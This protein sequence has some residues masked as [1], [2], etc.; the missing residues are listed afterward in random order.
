[1]LAV[2]LLVPACSSMVSQNRRIESNKCWSSMYNGDTVNGTAVLFYYPEERAFV[3]ND[4][5]PKQTIDIGAGGG[6]KV[7]KELDTV[8]QKNNTALGVRI[9][10]HLEGK[11]VKTKG[12]L[13]NLISISAMSV[14]SKESLK[15]IE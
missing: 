7:F 9:N 11:I 6:A 13:N 8:F 2:I 4:A 1:M 5:C 15:I 10:V 3:S 14:A 12:N